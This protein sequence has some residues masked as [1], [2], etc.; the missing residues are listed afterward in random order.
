M[1]WVPAELADAV[2]T[3]LGWTA[4]GF[5][6]AAT[7]SNMYNLPL[8]SLTH[9]RVPLRAGAPSIPAL[10]VKVHF[11]ASVRAS[12]ASSCPGVGSSWSFSGDVPTY[13][14]LS[15]GSNTGWR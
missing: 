14:R 13:T 10:A 4:D 5:A 2:T 11:T 9:S 1:R 3:H 7:V 8:R 15:A 12:S 6:T